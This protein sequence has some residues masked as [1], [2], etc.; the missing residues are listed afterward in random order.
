MA[1]NPFGQHLASQRGR[2]SLVLTRAQLEGEH[3]RI[4]RQLDDPEFADQRDE[5][6]KELRVVNAALAKHQEV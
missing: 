3:T 6:L 1:R 2:G 4:T 5:L